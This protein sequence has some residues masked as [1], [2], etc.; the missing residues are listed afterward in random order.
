MDDV[1]RI[2]YQISPV[3][4]SIH[5]ED[6]TIT[7]IT[8]YENNLYVGTSNGQLLHFHRFDDTTEY[9]PITT[10]NVGLTPYPKSYALS[11]FRDYLSYQ[12][13][14]SCPMSC[15]NFPHVE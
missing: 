10:I 3:I 5:L 11:L 12:I 1:G 2:R 8:T 9:I 15:Q 7:D 14:L 4:E 6:E 13:V